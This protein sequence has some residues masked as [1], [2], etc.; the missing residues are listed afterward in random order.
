VP[1]FESTSELLK[2]I[3]EDVKRK[4]AEETESLRMLMPVR[5]GFLRDSVKF[6]E[7]YDKDGE[8]FFRIEASAE[9]AAKAREEFAASIKRLDEKIQT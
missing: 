8:A 2:G 9:Y 3:V 7:E 4:V 5:T 6:Y 1:E